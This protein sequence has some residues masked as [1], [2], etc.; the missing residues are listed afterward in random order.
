MQSERLA[1]QKAWREQQLHIE[2]LKQAVNVATSFLE[3]ERLYAQLVAAQKVAPPRIDL[4]KEAILLTEIQ[5][6]QRAERLK[7]EEQR[8]KAAPLPADDPK[9][10]L[11]SGY[12][13]LLHF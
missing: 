8:L 2:D 7:N 4:N 1:H 13:T 3:K 12:V 9:A 11:L 6:L 10:T 5:Q